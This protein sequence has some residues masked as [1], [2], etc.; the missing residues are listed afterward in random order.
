M[1]KHSKP[2]QQSVVNGSK[3][4]PPPDYE[5][6]DIPTKPPE[7]LTYHERRADLLQQVR[8]LGHPSMINQAEAADRY[9]VSQQQI[10]KD[11]AR[12]AESVHEHV[13]DRD[14]RAF[15]VDAVAQRAI[16][17]LLEEGEYR[18]AAKTA[19]EWDEW[20]TE[21]HDLDKLTENVERLQQQ[22]EREGG[23]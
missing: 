13:V 10:S 18:K 16:R 21:F 6:V 5:T 8:D 15:T 2:A 12:I 9:G 17:G 19:I 11:L 23:L 7:D 14:R 3:N 20:L 4:Q 1:S 22:Q